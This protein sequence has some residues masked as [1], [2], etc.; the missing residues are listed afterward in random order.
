MLKVLLFVM[1]LLPSMALSFNGKLSGP[2][3]A[4]YSSGTELPCSEIFLEMKVT[5]TSFELIQGGYIC[6]FLQAGF[7]SFKMDIRNGE[8][9]HKDQKLGYI[10]DNKISYQV[11]DP[12]DGSTYFFNLAKEQSGYRYF[13]EWDDGS[14]IALKVFGVLDLLP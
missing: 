1:L 12:A 2:G 4:I 7:D 5:Q 14:K 3:N 11:Y 13:E 6:G 10:S 9:W 8:L